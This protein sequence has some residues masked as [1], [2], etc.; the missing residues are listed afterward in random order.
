MRVR[1]LGCGVE[2]G[3]WGSLGFE[4]E[5]WGLRVLGL[6]CGGEGGSLG[7]TLLSQAKSGR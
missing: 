1:G 4:V 2:A 7:S 3:T 5:G 6:E